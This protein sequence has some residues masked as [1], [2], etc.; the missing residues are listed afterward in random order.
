MSAS[1]GHDG[2]CCRLLGDWWDE[3]GDDIAAAA[4]ATVGG[5]GDVAVLARTATAAGLGV[6]V[7]ALCH[8]TAV[9]PK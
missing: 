2:D 5:G 3:D 7:T 1:G 4:A 8:V 6:V 9:L